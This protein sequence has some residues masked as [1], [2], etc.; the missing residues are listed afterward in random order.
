[1]K[2][3]P[4]GWISAT[5]EQ[6]AAPE[7][8]ALAIGPFG[9]NLR[10]ADYTPS[11]TP[12]VFV[13]NIRT[14]TFRGSSTKYVSDDKALELR[15][16]AVRRGDILI[17]KMGDPPGDV[18]LYQ[19]ESPAIITADCIKLTPHPAVDTRYLAF[20]F[21]SPQFR[22]QVIEI[23]KGVAQRKVSLGRFRRLVLPLAPPAEQ[24]LIV[25][26]IEEQ[27]SRLDDA[28]ASL[29]RSSQKLPQ[30]HRASLQSML[31]S[32]DGTTGEPIA[33]LLSVNIGGVWGSVPG[34]DEVDVSV[35][36]VTEFKEHGRLDPTTAAVRSVTKRQFESRQLESGDLLLEKS[37]GGPT[38]PV[39][40]VA[41]V[42]SYDG[43]A[44]CSNFVQLLRPDPAKADSGYLFWALTKLYLDGWAARHQRATTNIRN[45]QTKDYL[46]LAVPL[47]SLAEQHSI[48]SQAD[49]L[50]THEEA[51][52]GQIAVALARSRSFRQAILR[53]A[54]SGTLMGSGR[55]GARA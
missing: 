13:R 8:N 39:G 3:L 43:A 28:E 20:I 1:M 19:E 51:V 2:H 7:G 44:V 37:G 53:D 45:L 35:F 12:L 46:R 26:A 30:Y 5:V 52:S 11:G 29:R 24:R 18:A 27:F 10:V 49:R 32:F 50:L 6:V 17:T 4:D 23:T 22:R 15:S 41:R 16:H 48:A 36:R 42:P 47:P 33:E 31:G 34:S 54:Y 38:K 14:K 40:R 9:S 21:A 25:D 55:T